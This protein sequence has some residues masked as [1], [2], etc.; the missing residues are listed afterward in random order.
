MAERKTYKIELTAKQYQF[1]NF[2]N[3]DF[4][5]GKI[6]VIIH[7]SDPQ[8]TIIKEIKRPFDGKTKLPIDRSIG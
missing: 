8:E 1:I 6:E 2:L 3:N 4:K 7:N 5:F